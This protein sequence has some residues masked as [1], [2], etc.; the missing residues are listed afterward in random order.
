MFGGILVL[1]LAR[2]V[3]LASPDVFEDYFND[4]VKVTIAAI[5]SGKL[6][7]HRTLNLGRVKE[8]QIEP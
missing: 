5:F 8:R 4:D 7:L 1:L 3:L 2:G 6:Y